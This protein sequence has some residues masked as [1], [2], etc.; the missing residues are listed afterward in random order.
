MFDRFSME[1]DWRKVGGRLEEGR[2]RIGRGL[3]EDWTRIGG[4]QNG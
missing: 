1:E 2:R 4:A 3:R